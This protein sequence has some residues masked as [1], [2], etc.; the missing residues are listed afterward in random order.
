M[1][2]DRRCGFSSPP[3]VGK[4]CVF[5]VFD[6]RDIFLFKIKIVG[7]FTAIF[8]LWLSGFI[9]GIVG[10]VGV[11]CPAP[12]LMP[13]FFSWW[14]IGFW[15]RKPHLLPRCWFVGTWF[16]WC[17]WWFRSGRSGFCLISS[18]LC[19]LCFNRCWLELTN[20]KGDPC[21]SIKS[22][23]VFCGMCGRRRGVMVARWFSLNGVCSRYFSGGIPT[24]IFVGNV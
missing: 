13:H 8:S 24:W 11:A 23:L 10:S 9:S 3:S 6:S 22:P 16:C 5:F 15:L 21:V 4:V 19:S 14:A 18:S 7:I 20:W 1:F 17:W 12:V 2:S